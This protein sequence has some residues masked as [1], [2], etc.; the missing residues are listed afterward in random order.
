[1]VD[2]DSSTLA[3]AIR[4]G[5]RRA[6]ARA[7]TLAEN[8][9]SAMRAL[10][11]GL[12][13]GLGRARRIG[14][15]GPPGAGK[16]TLT[17]RLA[18]RLGTLGN[19][20]AVIA[21]DPSSPYSHGA[22]LGDRIRMAAVAGDERVFIRSMA[23]RGTLG[24]LAAASADA[25]DIFDAAGYQYILIETVGV[26]QSEIEIARATDCTIVVVTPESGDEVQAAK[27]G[28]LEIADLL[29]VNK[30]DRPASDAMVATLQSM[31]DGRRQDLAPQA[32]L[33]QLLSTVATD[34]RGTDRLCDAIERHQAHQQQ[35]GLLA[36]RRLQRICR[37]LESA[38]NSLLVERFWSSE[39]RARLDRLAIDIAAGHRDIAGAIE[40]ITG[41][42]E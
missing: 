36:E 5:E 28:L 4:R 2:T 11:P 25:A 3:A 40:T 39:R 17:M 15:T 19:S 9:R 6:I 12:S 16:S 13:A 20:V 32:W 41:D 34:D 33:P 22:L 7:I 23:N 14:L 35:T 30:A 8:D 29:V 1:M 18:A 21:I 26:G 37:R 27:A 38:T 42:N 10:A 24:G 31:L